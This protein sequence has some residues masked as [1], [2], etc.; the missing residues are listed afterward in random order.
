MANRLD[1]K[2]AVVTASTKGI[3]KAIA[4]S[5]IDE[6]AKVYYAV[7]NPKKGQKLVDAAIAK[8]CKADMVYF[9]ANDKESIKNM[10]DEVVEKEGR[11]DILVNNFGG[12][13]PT[14]DLD[15]VNGSWDVFSS[16]VER[17]LATVFIASQ[18]AIKKAMI[19]Q[20]SGSIINIG[21]VAGHTPDLTQCGYGVAKAG[22]EFLTKQMALHTGKYNIR[23][24]VLLPGITA[25]DAVKKYLPKALQEQYLGGCPIHRLAEPEEMASLAVYLGSDESRYVTGQSIKVAGG[26]DFCS[27]IYA[28]SQK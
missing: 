4:A 22:I 10:I 21:S 6:G 3:G 5:F 9:E 23:A 13:D 20:G 18:E 2:I 8:G 27:P 28:S 17:N 11:L 19:P 25:T 16:T 24:N 7:R 15:I 26:F 14:V 1:G 12:S